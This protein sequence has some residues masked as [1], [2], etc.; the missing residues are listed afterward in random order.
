MIC[1]AQ[2]SGVSSSSLLQMRVSDRGMTSKDAVAPIVILL[3]GLMRGK[4]SLDDMA[5]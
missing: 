2:V 4:G 1:L 5:R 3:H